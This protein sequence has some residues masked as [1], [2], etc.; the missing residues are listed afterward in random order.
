[1]LE[2]LL[3]DCLGI[4]ER[5]EFMGVNKG[6][7]RKINLNLNCDR[8]F[9][10]CKFKRYLSKTNNKKLIMIDLGNIKTIIDFDCLELNFS[11]LDDRNKLLEI[12]V[13]WMKYTIND[14]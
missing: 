4:E 14:S 11:F 1:M 5:E 2:N 7:K 9:V 6:I 13:E 12:I 10:R 3:M 8:A